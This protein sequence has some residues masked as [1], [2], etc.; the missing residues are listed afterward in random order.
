MP[1]FL[2][3]AF[4]SG[5]YG[6]IICLLTYDILGKEGEW[7]PAGTMQACRVQVHSIEIPEEKP[8]RGEDLVC[9]MVPEAV[10]SPL[11]LGGGRAKHHGMQG[12]VRE[13]STYL[14]SAR[15][16]AG[17]GDWS[18]GCPSGPAK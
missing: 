9:L 5:K 15:T 6:Y 14:L 12:H 7:I 10:C 2:L 4:W 16:Q 18:Q 1:S 17:E 11:F 3:L 8:L 13:Q